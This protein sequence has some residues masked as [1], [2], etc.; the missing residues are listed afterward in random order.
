MRA[1]LSTYL[2]S[3]G[4]VPTDVAAGLTFTDPGPGTP[5]T[6]TLVTDGPNRAG[7]RQLIAVH[8]DYVLDGDDPLASAPR[9]ED[10]AAPHDPGTV[11][12]VS[13]IGEYAWPVPW[14]MARRREATMLINAINATLL[15][16]GA[17]SLPPMDPRAPTVGPSAVRFSWAV[18]IGSQRDLDLIDTALDAARE[19]FAT[20]LPALACVVIDGYPAAIAL[21]GAPVQVSKGHWTRRSG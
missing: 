5:L 2:R 20:L 19:A 11:P 14:S 6:C 4:I 16:V 3:R 17:L 8:A 10:L 15:P 7:T 18:P 1:L 13:V 21:G 9:T 12:T